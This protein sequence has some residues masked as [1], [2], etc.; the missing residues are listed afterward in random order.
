MPFFDELATIWR[1]IQSVV[2]NNK[3][4]IAKEDVIV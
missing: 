2:A 1:E 4:E 3:G